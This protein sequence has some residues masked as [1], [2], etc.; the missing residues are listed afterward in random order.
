MER[1]KMMKAKKGALM[2][3]IDAMKGLELEKMKGFK[4]KDD[5][6]PAMEAEMHKLDP[7]IMKKIKNKMEDDDDMECDE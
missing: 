1:G 5:D 2:S 7:K 6:K 4:K 3:L